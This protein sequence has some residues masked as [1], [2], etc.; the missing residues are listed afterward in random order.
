MD[1]LS[2][3]VVANLGGLEMFSLSS[4]INMV[5]DGDI[6][7]ASEHLAK[8]FLEQNK[9]YTTRED[10]SPEIWIYK[11]GILIPKGKAY[12]DE[13]CREKAEAHYRPSII[14]TVLAKV[15]ADTYIDPEKLFVNQNLNEIPVK[16]GVLNLIT[17]QLRD[18]D[19]D[20]DRFFN[21][22]PV[23]YNLDKKCPLID[24][25]LQEVLANPEDKKVMYEL[26]GYCLERTHFIEKAF[27]F[28]G[29]GR[30]G[31]GK[32][33]EIIKRFVGAESCCSVPLISMREDSFNLH[34]MHGKLVNLAGDLNNT[35]L[36]NTGLF[37]S[38]TGRDLITAHR[39]FMTDIIFVNHAKNV[40]ACN[41]LPKVYDLSKGFW[42]RWILLQFPYEFIS[43]SEFDKLDPQEREF[44]K[45]KDVDHIANIINDDEL[46]GLLNQALD[47]LDRLHKQKDFS[48][49][50]GTDAI[51]DTWIRKSNSFTAFCFDAVEPVDGGCV[52]KGDLRKEFNRYCRDY[53][54]KGAGDKEIKATLEDL[55]GVG[56]GRTEQNGQWVN[57]WTGIELKGYQGKMNSTQYTRACIYQ[58]KE[59]GGNPSQN[60]TDLI[61]NDSR[62]NI[63]LENVSNHSQKDEDLEVL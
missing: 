1:R 63:L 45:I 47:G 17:R 25:H 2:V 28:L 49:S 51:K 34:Q 30:N 60:N 61:N 35:D 11:D 8:S 13:F 54:L 27:M 6:D 40:F 62:N 16:N 55:F 32:T 53:K 39:K 56:E 26:I 36:K 15:K 59:K 31:K 4:F 3:F 37:K 52:I 7:S 43:Q 44:K 48:Y 18:Y 33:I 41:E 46:S 42:S 21:K 20:N 29:D 58:A 23:V 9:V 38:L 14:K 50:I 24:L 12:L 10:V 5:K 22:I 57:T 19:Q